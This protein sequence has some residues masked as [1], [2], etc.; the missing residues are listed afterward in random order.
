MNR[1]LYVGN[2]EYTVTAEELKQE[3][4]RFGALLSVKLLTLPDGRS[5]GFGFV[6][7]DNPDDAHEAIVGLHEKEF[8]GRKLV[9]SEARPPR[10]A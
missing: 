10:T 6:E 4:I 5:K 9:V 7:F 1:K 3:F 2:L 8:R